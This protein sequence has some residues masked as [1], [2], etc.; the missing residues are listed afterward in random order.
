MFTLPPFVTQSL[1]F[2]KAFLFAL[3]ALS[4]DELREK[5]KTESVHCFVLKNIK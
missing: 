2:I 3:F 1:D 4:Y 5:V